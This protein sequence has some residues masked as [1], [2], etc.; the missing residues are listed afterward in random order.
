MMT[1]EQDPNRINRPRSS[2]DSASS[3]WGLIVIALVVAGALAFIFLLLP[4]SDTDTH[5]TQNAPKV[6]KPAT[7]PTPTPATPP[8]KSPAP[9][10]PPNGTPVPSTPPAQK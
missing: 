2:Y 9:T 5:L 1:F 10:T 4:A 3:S 6:Q 7:T 8:A